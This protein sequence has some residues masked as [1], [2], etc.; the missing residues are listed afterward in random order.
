M[1]DDII[2]ISP[3]YD[4]ARRVKPQVVKRISQ[5]TLE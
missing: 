2:D 3:E 1:V 4:Y 5:G